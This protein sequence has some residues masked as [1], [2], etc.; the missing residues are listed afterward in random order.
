MV[1][2]VILA[3]AIFAVL[4]LVRAGDLMAYGA[5]MDT[6]MAQKAR[7]RIGM[8]VSFPFEGF[9]ES[10]LSLSPTSEVFEA[11]WG[12]WDGENPTQAFPFTHRADRDAGVF[13]EAH[14]LFQAPPLP[15]ETDPRPVF[16]YSELVTLFFFAP[17]G[18]PT[19]P[20]LAVSAR[21]FYDLVWDD[22]LTGVTRTF[23]FN[24]LRYASVN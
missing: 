14:S 23:S 8:L 1:S 16:P 20:D 21:F 3:F 6:Q 24:F 10:A 5:Q 17:D 12:L 19:T 4:G 9:R 22:P 2:A 13:D 11:Q 15:G 7:E 18:S